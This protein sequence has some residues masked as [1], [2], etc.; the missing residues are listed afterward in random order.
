MRS[1]IWAVALVSLAAAP[2]SGELYQWVDPQGGVHV[3]ENLLEVPAE[4]RPRADQAAVGRARHP[5]SERRVS[6]VEPPPGA[7]AAPASAPPGRPM[8]HRLPIA[9]AGHEIRLDVELDGALTVP[10]IADTGA[11]VNTI[12]RWAVEKLGIEIPR[13][14]PVIGMSGVSGAGMRAPLIEVD[15][16]RVGTAQV[17]RVE[18][19]VIDTLDTGLLGMPFFNNFKVQI[20]PAQGVMTLEEI[21][22]GAIDGLYG[23]YDEVMWRKKYAQIRAERA[24]IDA[25][26]DRV[27]SS[28]TSI[29]EK[30]EAQRDYWDDQLDQLE[31]RAQRAGVPHS[32][33]E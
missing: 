1:W 30:L 27:P 18:M 31:E 3:T 28:Y 22:P 5:D 2:A 19:A 6:R 10:F 16:V 8:V 21:A 17:E 26:I 9:R 13:D 20:D 15:S 11:S 4:Q 29:I 33:R 14:A 32:W 24:R 12:P 23:G 25:A 7:A